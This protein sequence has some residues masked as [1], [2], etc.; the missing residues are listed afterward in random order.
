MFTY[1]VN[2][3]PKC[4]VACNIYAPNGTILLNKGIT[5]TGAFIGKAVIVGNTANLTLANGFGLAGAPTAAHIDNTEEANANGLAPQKF[6]LSQNYPNPFNPSTTI[7]Y[8]LAEQK[9][10]TLTIY[11]VL[12]QRVATLIDAI[13][14]GGYHDVRWDGR[15]SAGEAVSS[16]VYL[17]RISAGEFSD[18]KRMVIIK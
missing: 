3:N 7:R 5:A 9:H 18:V 13:Q 1:A 4:V 16:G 10:V 17:L 2:M 8:S 14:P 12:G 11:N 6:S 15:N